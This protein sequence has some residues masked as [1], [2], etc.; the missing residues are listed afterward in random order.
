MED[1]VTFLIY[2]GPGEVRYDQFG[3]VDLGAFTYCTAPVTA[4]QMRTITWVC[5]WLI[6][7]FGM[8]QESYDVIVQGLEWNG[9]W[10]LKPLN[11]TREW[12]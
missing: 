9:V 5:D 12:R 11:R 4:P 6:G 3:G 10:V 1:T 7:S 8:D 2:Y